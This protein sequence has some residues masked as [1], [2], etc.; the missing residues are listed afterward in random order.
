MKWFSPLRGLINIMQ[1]EET[2]LGQA[3]QLVMELVV[4]AAQGLSSLAPGDV[5][6]AQK[7]VEER[8]KMFLHPLALLT[9]VPDHRDTQIGGH[10]C[11]GEV[12]CFAEA[13]DPASG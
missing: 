4:P 5:R 3:V 10:G 2:T 13:G 6:Q 7:Y 8:L 11:H 1:D 12:L 9:N